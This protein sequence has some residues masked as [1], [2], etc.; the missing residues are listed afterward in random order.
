MRRHFRTA[1]SRYQLGLSELGLARGVVDTI[2]R[3]GILTG[4]RP[5][6]GGG[7]FFP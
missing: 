6:G 4:S 3:P 5:D 1:R 2:A 7:L